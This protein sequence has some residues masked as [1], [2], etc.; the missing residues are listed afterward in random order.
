M[1]KLPL[2]EV[3]K[4][5]FPGKNEKE[6]F[7]AVLRGHV[8]VDGAKA[9]KPRNPVSPAAGITLRETPRFVSRGGE[10]LAH[11]LD[12]WRHEAVGKFFI[13]AGASTGGFTDC[14]LQSGAAGVYAVDVGRNQLDYRLRTDPRVTVMGCRNVMSLVSGDFTI[15]PH[16]AVADLSFRSLRRAAL[17]IL[18]LTSEGTGIFLAKPQFEA[19]DPGPDFDGVIRDT[20]RLE[21]IMCGL[22]RDLGEEGVFVR[23]AVKSPL[24]G[25]KG[26]REFL[27]MLDRGDRPRGFSAE[28]AAAA[29]IRE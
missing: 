19:G 8:S 5:R 29:L 13:D 2:L 28:R 16:Q 3:L 14:L 26:N 27:L 20:A 22:F 1:R 6:L 24:L 11:A 23:K 25:R 17:H 18:A 10:K 7:A 21:D 12:V 4:A 15:Q 9:L